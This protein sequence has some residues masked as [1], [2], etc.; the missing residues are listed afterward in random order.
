MGTEASLSGM[1]CMAVFRPDEVLLARQVASIRAQTFRDWNCIV[2]IDGADPR[3]E[4]L[5]RSL[6]TG[7]DRFNIVVYE[8][9]IGFYGN[10]ER[11]LREVSASAK[12]VALSDQDDEW[13]PEKLERLVPLLDEASLAFGQ[14]H[15]VDRLRNQPP[16]LTRRRV[17]TLPGELIDNQVTGSACVF[18][19]ELLSLALPFPEWTRYAYHDHWL[20]V[21]ALA[22]DGIAAVDEALQYYVQHSDNVIGEE[23]PSVRERVRRLSTRA[24]GG[25][26]AQ[27]EYVRDHRW[28][29]RVNM[30]SALSSRRRLV[31]PGDA[32]LVETVA[33]GRFGLGLVWQIAGAVVHGDAPPLRA[34]TLLAG[35]VRGRPTR[36]AEPAPR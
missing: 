25:W 7:D 32:R 15:V 13:F 1:V 28:G 3:A 18:R 12:W 26:N 10:F 19:R 16:T 31:R 2:G 8:Q 5:L 24:G 36:L 23:D 27:W 9:N 34:L 11:V 17:P 20:G 6:V 33:R 35:A 30:A 14:A 22:C 21:C 29:W 4:A